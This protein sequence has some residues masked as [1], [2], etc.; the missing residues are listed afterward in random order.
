[1]HYAGRNRCLFQFL[2]KN[3]GFHA[4]NKLRRMNRKREENFPQDFQIH[5]SH[6]ITFAILQE[7]AIG[8]TVNLLIGA[9]KTSSRQRDLSYYVDMTYTD[10]FSPV[11]SRLGTCSAPGRGMRRYASEA[12]GD[13]AVATHPGRSGRDHCP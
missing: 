8:K 3:N 9:S 10:G 7:P 5:I 2:L 1:M 4:P 12:G 11:I 13:C 6:R